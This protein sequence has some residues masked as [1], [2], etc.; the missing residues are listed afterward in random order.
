MSSG[1]SARARSICAI[2]RLLDGDRRREALRASAGN[3]SFG[4]TMR[5]Q[6]NF[7]KYIVLRGSLV[8]VR[9]SV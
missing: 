3:V 2:A 7:G 1:L 9:E 5:G 8:F 6:S 4:F